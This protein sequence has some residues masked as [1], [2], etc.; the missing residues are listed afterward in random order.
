[1]K[2]TAKD[3]EGN[4]KE[5]LVY[6]AAS[7]GQDHVRGKILERPPE[8]EEEGASNGK[9]CSFDVFKVPELPPEEEVAEGEEAPPPRPTPV[10]VPLKIDN[11]MRDKR[12][13][14]FGIPLLGAY[15]AV[16]TH[17]LTH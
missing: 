2:K 14:F 16:L 15:V 6:T 9:G 1:V 8:S 5:I 10:P 7:N 12:I 4:D 11:V 13:K 3:K 17:S